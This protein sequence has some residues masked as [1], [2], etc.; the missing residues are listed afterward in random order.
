MGL[1]DFLF[2][3]NKTTS[4]PK[5]VKD[6]ESSKPLNLSGDQKMLFGVYPKLKGIDFGKV[7]FGASGNSPA[8]FFASDIDGEWYY[9]Q[10]QMIM[11]F[12][13]FSKEK[14]EAELKLLLDQ[15]GISFQEKIEKTEL[16]AEHWNG[17]GF[18]IEHPVMGGVDVIIITNE[19][20]IPKDSLSLKQTNLA[21]EVSL[22]AG[23]ENIGIEHVYDGSKF[24]KE[25]NGQFSLNIPLLFKDDEDSLNY[26]IIGVSTLTVAKHII[27]NIIDKNYGKQ[28]FKKLE[29]KG[30][31]EYMYANKFF[32]IGFLPKY[33]CVRINMLHNLVD[34]RK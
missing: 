4:N 1:L 24:L 7:K 20:M 23:Y 28:Y 12:K 27:N 18:Q 31:W 34:I 16:V 15:N 17:D 19:N 13:A 25:N 30:G 33:L 21:P 14:F 6:S 22:P 11:L 26:I 2:G 9:A 3:K 5:G 29:E 32:V 8:E 10:S